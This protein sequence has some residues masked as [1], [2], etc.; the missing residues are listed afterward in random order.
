MRE[1][2]NMIYIQIDRQTVKRRG[3]EKESELNKQTEN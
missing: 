2:D 3:R 1:T